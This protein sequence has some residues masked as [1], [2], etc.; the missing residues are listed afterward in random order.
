MNF[1]MTY[2]LSL[3]NTISWKDLEVHSNSVSGTI[4][5][6][7]IGWNICTSDVSIPKPDDVDWCIWW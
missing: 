5:N 2:E 7:T 1:I 3:W 6:E 4:Y